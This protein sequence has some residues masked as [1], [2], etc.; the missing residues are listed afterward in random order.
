MKGFLIFMALIVGGSAYFFT[1]MEDIAK[2]M[3]ESIEKDEQPDAPAFQE[4]MY[5]DPTQFAVLN[6]PFLDKRAQLA[7]WLQ[8]LGE[9][10]AF[11]TLALRT[12]D[13]YKDSSL[14][15]DPSY[16]EIL[17]R[18]AVVMEDDYNVFSAQTGY[19]LCHQYM[20]LFPEGVH[21][22]EVSA[23]ANRMQSK[24]NFK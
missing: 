16:G 13:L 1:H 15:T 11:L 8:I 4:L 14:A 10:S 7:K 5:R 17:Y 21:K 20:A 6:K 19:D 9:R 3:T 23:I 12:H 18:N 24:F 2:Q 22:D